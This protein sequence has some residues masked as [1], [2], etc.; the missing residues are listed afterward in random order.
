MKPETPPN[1][2]GPT[3]II[4]QHRGRQAQPQDTGQPVERPSYEPHNGLTQ[5]K[6]TGKQPSLNSKKPKKQVL[7][8]YPLQQLCRPQ[9]RESAGKGAGDNQWH[10]KWC[11]KGHKKGC[12]GAAS[13]KPKTAKFTV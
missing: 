10:E 5:A 1:A 13:P 2:N 11:M 12:E 6:R 7:L 9:L 3:S 4:S 8:A